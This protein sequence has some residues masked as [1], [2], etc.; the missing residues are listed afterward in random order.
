MPEILDH[1]LP[2]I[3]RIEDPTRQQVRRVA[4]GNQRCGKCRQFLVVEDVCRADGRDSHRSCAEI[5]NREIREGAEIL[6]AQDAAAEV[7][8]VA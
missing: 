6:A 5:W 8:Q 4:K 1:R 2:P 3:V 7:E